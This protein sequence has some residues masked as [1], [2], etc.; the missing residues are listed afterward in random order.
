MTLSGHLLSELIGAGGYSRV[1]RAEPTN[2]GPAVAVKVAIRPELVLV[3][4]S[5][6]AL[7]RRLQ[8]PRFVQIL[9]EHLDQDPPFFV[10]ELCPGG[11]LRAFLDR[12]PGKRLAPDR[13]FALA[14]GILE[15][16]AFAHEEGVV[17]GD[18]KPENV[19][20][21]AQGEPKIA[22]LGLS[23]AHRE[24]LIV[25]KEELA[26]TLET[27]ETKVRGTFDYLAPEVRKAHE[28]TPASDVYALGVLLYEMLTGSRPYGLFQL[29]ADVLKGDG[30]ERAGVAVPVALD[31]VV[32]RALAHEARDRYPDASVMLAD[33]RAGEAG[34]TLAR[35]EAVAVGKNPLLDRIADE[36]A[37]D[38]L[39]LHVLVVLPALLIVTPALLMAKAFALAATFLAIVLVY[40][41]LGVLAIRFAWRNAQ[42]HVEQETRLAL[43]ERRA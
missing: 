13:A 31:R 39:I 34:L 5:E 19:L 10:L 15:G 24:R 14:Q 42:W 18:L 7:L 26:N 41:G 37:R 16:V 32:A 23:R 3:L 20:L 8:G 25:T 36:Q 11:D 40:A 1:F 38:R 17:H 9:E 28:I 27:E 35:P 43:Q 33:L 21:D 4:R 22:D 6:G 2:G 12:A 30:D 29:P